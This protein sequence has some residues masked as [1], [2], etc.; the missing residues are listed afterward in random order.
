MKV[1]SANLSYLW[2]YITTFALL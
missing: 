2:A 1:L